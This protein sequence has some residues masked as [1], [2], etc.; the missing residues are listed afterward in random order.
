MTPAPMDQ[1]VR[2]ARAALANNPDMPPPARDAYRRA[3]DR[4][5][6]ARAL[7]AAIKRQRGRT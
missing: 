4:A 2:N 6:A 1:I 3:I 5:Q 7:A